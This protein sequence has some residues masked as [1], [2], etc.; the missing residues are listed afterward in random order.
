MPPVD[1]EA[2]VSV[3]GGG[4]SDWEFSRKSSADSRADGEDRSLKFDTVNGDEKKSAVDFPPESFL[5]S[6]DDGIDWF[7]RNAVLERKE[8]GKGGANPNPISSNP[9]SRSSSQR[10]TKFRGGSMIGLPRAQKSVDLMR[11]SCS[12]PAS[13]RLFPPR[14]SDSSVGEPSSPK[15]SCIGR[16]RSMRGRR[17]S[18]SR[19]EHSL[20]KSRSIVEKGKSG[21]RFSRFISVLLSSRGHNRGKKTP[22]KKENRSK[23]E[24]QDRPSRKSMKEEVPISY[25]PAPGLGGMKRFSSGRRSESWQAS[26][27][28]AAICEAFQTE[29]L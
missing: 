22:E 7:D 2:L 24:E 19:K 15:V 27:I 21:F 5:L 25:E 20:E 11:R 23:V 16:V 3:S 18:A 9:L 8:S 1:L 26:E 10:L 13:I 29:R 12:K 28:N 6:K 17:E 14:R 4:G